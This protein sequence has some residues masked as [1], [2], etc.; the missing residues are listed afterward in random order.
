MK[1]IFLIKLTFLY[2]FS[3]SHFNTNNNPLFFI[4]IKKLRGLSPQAN[5]TERP[6]LVS[7]VNANFFADRGFHMVS[8]PNPYGSILGFL[9]RS[10]YY[11]IQV[12]LHLYAVSGPRS[13]PS[14]NV[15]APR[16]EPGPPDLYPGT[17]TT[18]PQRRHIYEN[19]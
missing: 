19:Y 3:I 2:D 6:P 1:T 16:I 7:E 18:R 10:R 17:L 13:R 11:F 15:V 8:M 12:A 4:Y 14:E 9:D 5:Y